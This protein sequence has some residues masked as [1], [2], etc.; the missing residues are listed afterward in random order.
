MQS[1]SVLDSS[2]VSV[3]SAE[4]ASGHE[5]RIL[6]L[7][8]DSGYGHVATARAL[9]AHL[10]AERPWRID[11][12]DVYREILT[13]LDPFRALTGMSGP[14]FYNE[15]TLRRGHTRLLWPM[16]AVGSSVAIRLGSPFVVRQ[17]A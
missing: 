10:P 9:Q 8:T 2:V 15:Y 11:A 3:A 16:I 17:L 7:Y 12:V 5:K 14:D 13:T 4:P 1:S 6:V